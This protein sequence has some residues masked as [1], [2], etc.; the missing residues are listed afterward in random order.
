MNKTYASTR[1]WTST[2]RKLRLVAALTEK[3]GTEVLEQ[4]VTQELAR[5]KKA[6]HEDLR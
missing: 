5:I 4:L 2:A 1:V 6:G 3:S